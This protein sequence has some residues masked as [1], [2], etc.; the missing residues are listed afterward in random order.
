MSEIFNFPPSLPQP[1]AA[2][3]ETQ[4]AAAGAQL[5][6]VEENAGTDDAN[7][8]AAFQRAAPGI[9]GR[10]YISGDRAFGRGQH[11]GFIQAQR[12][13]MSQWTPPVNQ[14]QIEDPFEGSVHSFDNALNARDFGARSLHPHVA[15]RVGPAAGGTY[16]LLDQTWTAFSSPAQ[17]PANANNLARTDYMQVSHLQEAVRQNESVSC[18]LESGVAV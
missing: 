11:A 16:P 7:T 4:Q 15:D 18:Y 1:R 6:P 10:P 5:G 14:T 9:F 17:Y 13:A 2:L 12:H 8:P 3:R